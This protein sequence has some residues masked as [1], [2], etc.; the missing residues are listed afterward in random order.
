[1]FG[2]SP[3]ANNVY[4]L[5]SHRTSSLYE[6]SFKVEAAINAACQ[7]CE[8]CP[9]YLSILLCILQRLD[10]SF[11]VIN[12]IFYHNA[13]CMY[14]VHSAQPA[15]TISTS[16]DV[17]TCK[18]LTTYRCSNCAYSFLSRGNMERHYADGREGNVSP[19][20]TIKQLGTANC[21][22]CIVNG[23]VVTRCAKCKIAAYKSI[24]KFEKLSKEN[25]VRYI[26]TN[27][28]YLNE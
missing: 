21:Y 16:G 1:M 14:S 13:N 2:R 23:L 8:K 12:G 9:F 19:K 4:C 3:L 6:M 25:L 27:G 15:F 7:I 17:I 10:L 11:S 26:A 18:V 22:A 20:W 28:G 24:L 5:L